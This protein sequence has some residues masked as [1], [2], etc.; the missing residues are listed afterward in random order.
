MTTVVVLGA[1]GAM[2]VVVFG[3]A[4]VVFRANRRRQLADPGNVPGLLRRV[5]EFGSRIPESEW[6]PV[7]VALDTLLRDFMILYEADSST[8]YPALALVDQVEGMLDDRSPATFS[9][10]ERRKNMLHLMEIYRNEHDPARKRTLRVFEDTDESVRP[11]DWKE[12]VEET[13][14]RA[15]N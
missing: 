9:N 5:A 7:T 8:I 13:R 15:S 11:K 1:V 3:I 14:R 6:E 4:I 2:L 10:T 12:E